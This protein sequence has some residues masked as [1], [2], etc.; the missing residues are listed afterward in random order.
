[1]ADLV[2]IDFYGD[3]ILARRTGEGP[4]DVEVSL[5]RM[6]EN[7]GCDFKTQL[8]KLKRFA[9][10]TMGQSPTV[11]EDGKQRFMTMMSLGS[12]P[13]W[14]ATIDAD[15]VAPHV[16]EKLVRY[17]L[18]CAE[19]LA[20]HFAPK[21][22]AARAASVDLDSLDSLTVLASQLTT[23]LIATTQRAIAAETKV[24]EQAEVIA[25]VEPKAR[26]FDR[27]LDTEGLCCLQDAGR[28]LNVGPNLF[29]ETLRVAKVITRH[30]RSDIAYSPFVDA[31][32]FKH[33]RVPFF[34][35]KIGRDETRNQ[36]LFTATG[37][38]WAEDQIASG[39]LAVRMSKARARAEKRRAA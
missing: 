24:A 36:A 19:V 4:R 38:A 6:C 27:F 18:E 1:M 3:T 26:A 31:G 5:R 11:A 22:E 33:R 17:Q 25:V 9:W 16:R 23:K 7:L 29:I 30:G 21:V 37:L 10:A 15:R 34:N 8:D 13:M 39:K 12:V 28:A 32:Y 20:N 35:P 2:S 14:L